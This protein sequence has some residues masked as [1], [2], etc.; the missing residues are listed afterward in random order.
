MSVLCIDGVIFF[1]IFLISQPGLGGRES[2]SL[3][4]SLTILGVAFVKDVELSFL[5][6]SIDSLKE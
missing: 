5:D 6:V 3:A 2:N 1:K 4:D